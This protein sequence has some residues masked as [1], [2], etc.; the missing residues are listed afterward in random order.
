VKVE[1]T[2][3][4]ADTIAIAV[5]VAVLIVVV[6][7]ESGSSCSYEF[8]HSLSQVV[9]LTVASSH[10]RRLKY[11]RSQIVAIASKLQ[12]HSQSKVIAV[13]STHS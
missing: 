13:A 12:S 11:L 6:T 1:V 3:V 10:S 8:P 4:F 9:A 2:A 7:V 5:V